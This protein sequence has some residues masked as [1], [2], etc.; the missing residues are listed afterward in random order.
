MPLIACLAPQYGA[1][2]GIPRYASAEPTWTIVPRSRGCIRASAARVP[3]TA[4]EVR[5]PRGALVLVR[6]DVIEVRE[7]GRH[8]VVDPDVERPVRLLDLAGGASTCVVL[9]HVGLDRRRPAELPTSLAARLE[10]GAPPRD[11]ADC[12]AVPREFLAT[13][14]PIPAEA[15]VTTTTLRSATPPP[16]SDLRRTCPSPGRARR[17]RR[18]GSPTDAWSA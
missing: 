13:A 7:H 4:P 9:G 18:A 3:H 17:R 16:R 11:Q 10:A 12:G 2:S 8:R 5:D 6:V 14:R 1:W 15:P